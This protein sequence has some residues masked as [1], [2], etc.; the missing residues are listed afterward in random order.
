M[1]GTSRLLAVDVTVSNSAVQFGAP[2][3][4]LSGLLNLP[5]VRNFDVAADGTRFIVSA[6]ATTSALDA[7]ILI[8]ANW[9]P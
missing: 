4:L 7:P 6:L 9:D 5:G 1:D 8:V 3:M 2:K